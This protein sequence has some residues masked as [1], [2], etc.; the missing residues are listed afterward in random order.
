MPLIAYQNAHGNNDFPLHFCFF[1]AL[2][3]RGVLDRYD[4]AL[5]PFTD[6]AYCELLTRRFPQLVLTTQVSGVSRTREF[7]RKK[8]GHGI[9]LVVPFE[10][11]FDAVCEAPGGRIHPLYTGNLDIFWRY[12][13]ALRRAILFHSIEFGILAQPAVRRSIKQADLILARSRQSAVVAL[14]ASASPGKVFETCDIAFWQSPLPS[15]RQSGL[16]VAL[17]LPNKQPTE[18]YIQNV[19]A[20]LNYL[21]SLNHPIDQVLI[22]PPADQEQIARG[23]GNG[24]YSRITLWT[25][26]EMYT[27]FCAIRDGVISCR[28]HT[29]ILS[30][31][32]GNRKLLQ[33]QIEPETNKVAE[34]FGDI[35]LTGLAVLPSEKMT[36]T[37][38]RDFVEGENSLSEIEVDHALATARARVNQGLDV[39]EEWLSSIR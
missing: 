2:E 36:A 23:Y 11:R 16:A 37:R 39:F 29:T 34:I 1:E 33:F 4:F 27:P 32:A 35:G 7:I 10:R 38:V 25:G 31:L 3:R 15:K 9:R 21:E 28:L 20:V 17:R 8:I 5:D 22:E 13:R 19:R 24:I 26:N 30:L 12:P 18:D 6:A 14:R